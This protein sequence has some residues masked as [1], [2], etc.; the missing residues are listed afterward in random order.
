MTPIL[1]NLVRRVATDFPWLFGP[2]RES[3]RY[4]ASTF[5]LLKTMDFQPSSATLANLIVSAVVVRSP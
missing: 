2:S 1:T 4:T 5:S 3:A